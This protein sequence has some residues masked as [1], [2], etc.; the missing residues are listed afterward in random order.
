MA[1][2]GKK[3][4]KTTMTITIIIAISKTVGFVREMVMAAYFGQTLQSDAYITALG[5]LNIFTLLFSAGIGSTFIP[6]YTRSRLNDGLPTAN[7]YASNILNLYIIMGLLSSVIGYLTAP[8]L[9]SLIWQGSKEGLDMIIHLTRLMYPSI[10]FY[11]VAGVFV[12]I[13][14]AREK[15]V[16]E[17]L[18]GFALSLC[19]IGACFAFGSVEA[20][21]VAAALA[22]IVQVLVLLPFVRGNLKYKG[23][24]DLH[25]SNLKRTFILAIPALVS[26]AFDELNHQIDRIIGSGLQAGVVSSLDKSYTL[27]MTA[28]GILVV[29]LTTIMFSKLSYHAARSNTNQIIQ[30]YKKSIRVLAMITF[31]I[32]AIAIVLSRDIIASAYQHGIFSE[33][34]SLFTAPVF[35]FNILGLFAFGLRNFQTR[36]FYSIQETRTPMMIGIS[37]VILNTVLDIIMAK[38]M[39]APGLTLATTIA[40]AYAAVVMFVMIRRKLGD[41][42]FKTLYKPL[43]IT[44][45]STGAATVATILAK[46]YLPISGHSFKSSLLRFV[47]CGLIGVIVYLV[48]LIAISLLT[49]SKTGKG[50]E[51]RRRRRIQEDEE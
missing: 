9:C 18:T 29:P 16:P 50:M 24:L 30:N 43:G 33:A 21:S 22:G 11:A 17:Q 40:G 32:M 15:F 31:P 37:A 2:E 49:G 8:F 44:V 51:G 5:I 4:L 20:A 28:L 46:T 48:V 12:N 25:D 10:V 47:S 6:I 41:L 35:A 36:V 1:S 13:L 3:T 39:G 23:V 45:V 42:N 34:D 14:N 26:M 19:V 27:L 7:K 38:P